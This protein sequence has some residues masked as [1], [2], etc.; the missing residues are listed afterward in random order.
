M[1][2]RPS[3]PPQWIFIEQKKKKKPDDSYEEL[4]SVRGA[5]GCFRLQV[6]Q[7]EQTSH[8]VNQGSVRKEKEW[9]LWIRKK[10]QDRTPPGK[11]LR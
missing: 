7:E 11:D 6:D 5:G 3:H 2:T 10:R 1:E 8:T 4:R 9:Q